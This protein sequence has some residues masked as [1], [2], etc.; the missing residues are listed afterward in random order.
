MFAFLN[1]FVVVCTNGRT[2][3]AEQ[4]LKSSLTPTEIQL[5]MRE[6]AIM[7]QLRHPNIVSLVGVCTAGDPKML[8]MQLCEHGSL[9]DF[10]LRHTG[11]SELQFTSKLHIMGDVAHGMHFLS[12]LNIVHRD[13]AAR[14]VLVGADYICKVC[15]F[16][17]CVAAAAADVGASCLVRFIWF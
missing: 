16:S 12:S 11:L 7:V 14:N 2:A 13:L 1:T 17:F 9:L 6:A 4:M 3:N 10:L 5:F 15:S 8:V